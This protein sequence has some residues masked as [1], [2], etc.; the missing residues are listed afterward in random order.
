M[1]R[2]ANRQGNERECKINMAHGGPKDG[3]RIYIYITDVTEQ[4]QMEAKVNATEKKYK[5]LFDSILHG[6][7]ISTHDGKFIDCNQA[8][9]TM[10]WL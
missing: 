3:N 1:C 9:I 7:F 10:F 8:L 5:D 4:R 2:W 6:V